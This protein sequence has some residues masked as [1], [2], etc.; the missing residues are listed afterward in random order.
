MMQLVVVHADLIGHL[1][2]L[3]DYFLLAKGDFFQCFLEESRSLMRLPPRPPTAEADLKVP[4][5]QVLDTLLL[6][7]CL[8]CTSHQLR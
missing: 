8:L 3:K 7:K 4:F 2:A 1:K 5:Q 6:C